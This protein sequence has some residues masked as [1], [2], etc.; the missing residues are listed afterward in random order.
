METENSPTEIRVRKEKLAAAVFEKRRRIELR[1][2]RADDGAWFDRET[3]AK[4]SDQEVLQREIAREKAR[5][6]AVD[7]KNKVVVDRHWLTQQLGAAYDEGVEAGHILS[8][9]KWL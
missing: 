9:E 5:P 4:L 8:I 2:E 6:P 1:I 7:L 3:G